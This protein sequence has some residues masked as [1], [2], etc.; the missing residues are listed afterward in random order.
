[1][2]SM[3]S[4][5]GGRQGASFVIVKRFDDIDIPENTIYKQGCFA[6]DQDGYFYVPLIEKTGDNYTDYAAWGYIPRDGVTTVTSQEGV[7]SQPLELAYAE[8]MKQCFQKGGATA[9]QVGYGDYVIIDPIAGLGEYGNPNNGKVYR[10]GMNYD[11]DLGGAEYIGQIVGPK[12]D[13]PELQMTTIEEISE[14]PDSNIHHYDMTAGSAQDGI[15]PG[16]YVNGGL[17]NYNDDI[18]YGWA[19]IKDSF[20]NVTGALI[21]FTFPYLIPEF[22][23]YKRSAY[24]TQEDYDL[25]RISD[26]SLVGTAIRNSDNFLLLID[27][28]F[29][30]DD[31]DPSHGDTGHAF[32][33][34]WKL[35]IPQ[36]IK[37]DSQ[38]QLLII[39]GKVKIGSGLWSS[40]ASVGIDPPDTSAS[41]NNTVVSSLNDTEFDHMNLYPYDTTST[42]VGVMQTDQKYYAKL[43]DGSD[44]QVSYIQTTYDNLQV[45]ESQRIFIGDY[46]VIKDMWL[47]ADG[48]LWITY[49]NKGDEIIN[50]DNLIPWVTNIQIGQNGT[51]LIT[52]NNEENKDIYSSAQGWTWN[53][54]THTASKVLKFIDHVTIEDN[55]KIHFWYSNGEEAPNTG[56][57][58]IRLKYLQNVQIN[59]GLNQESEYDFDGEGS[60]SQKVEIT[61]NTEATP[62]TKDKSIIGAPLNYIMEAIVTTYDPK[63][64]NTPQDHL[65]VLYSDPAYRQWL[66]DKY[67]TSDPKTNKIWRY[68][69]QKFT[70]EN[71]SEPY[72]AVTP[73]GTENPQEE[74]WYEL[75]SGNYVLTEDTTVDISKTYY[76]KQFEF[77]T[78]N[79]WFDLGYVKGEPGGLHIIGE[80]VLQSGETYRDY[81]TDGVPPEDMP[82]NTHEDRGWSYL[83]TSDNSGE[84]QRIIY[85]YDYVHDKWTIIGEIGNI[86]LDPTQV[87]ILDA[88]TIDSGTGTII[89][90]NPNYENLPKENGL[91]FIKSTI[92]TAY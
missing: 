63:A 42:I 68:T 46:N 82:G 78:R 29:Q 38:T 75:V 14:Q 5:Y 8:G 49:T 11:D 9:S 88:A 24:Y 52:Y 80:Y 83:I 45:G 89:P 16:K 60:G 26:I 12:G 56:Y 84:T 66:I 51:F 62:G 86:T 2:G 92:K 81:L 17:V 70:Q 34:K 3:E 69:S 90:Q 50:D 67:S 59:T 57:T 74:G 15:V 87:V 39:P 7:T 35:S 37:G 28:D 58:N 54:A 10:R 19:T 85:T 18:T 73:I 20:G 47:T 76:E 23:S 71:I 41:N 36:G 22:V 64:P 25:G 53:S 1:M 61:W 65:L 31:R 44:L 79:D 43:E 13:S 91:W 55:G 6:K 21:G 77:V 32:Y 40:E 30:T 48:E 4:F 27:N 33:R 72:K